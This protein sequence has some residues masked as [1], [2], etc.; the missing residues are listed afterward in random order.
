MDVD[1][2]AD[3]RAD[4]QDAANIWRA[5][6]SGLADINLVYDA[7]FND[8]TTM[9]LLMDADANIVV[10]RTSDMVTVL[11]ADEEADCFGCV[12]GWMN[13]GGIHGPTHKAIHGA[14]VVDRITAPGIQIQVM[15]HEFGHVL[16]VPH[17]GAIQGLM[18]PAVIPGRTACLKKPDLVAF[19]GVNECGIHKMY[20]CE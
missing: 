13:A 8:L 18:Y 14:F 19:C 3:E 7:D 20:P 16:G 9:G 1:F 17:V 4:A 6:T 5:Q 15:I 11:K 12:L 2:T 10:R